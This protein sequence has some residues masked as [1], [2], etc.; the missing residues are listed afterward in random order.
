MNRERTARAF[1]TTAP[2]HG[3]LREQALAEPATG[4]VL[5]RARY[6]GISRGSSEWGTVGSMAVFRNNGELN[7]RF[8]VYRGR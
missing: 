8:G 3:E 7:F 5:V 2:G 1:W 6:S 4:E